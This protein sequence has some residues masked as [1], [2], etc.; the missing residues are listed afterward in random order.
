MTVC[1]DFLTQPPPKLHSLSGEYYWSQL[2]CRNCNFILHFQID[3]RTSRKKQRIF[4]QWTP[5]FYWDESILKDDNKSAIKFY[6]FLCVPNSSFLGFDLNNTIEHIANVYLKRAI[7][8]TFSTHSASRSP[9]NVG[10][11][12]S[13][14]HVREYH[15]PTDSIEPDEWYSTFSIIIHCLKC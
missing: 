11:C 1:H 12:I 8:S 7:H 5:F 2:I 9:G 4:G 3:G 15:T 10:V 14:S 13:F 6:G